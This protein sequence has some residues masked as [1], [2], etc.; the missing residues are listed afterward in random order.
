[1]RGYAGGLTR[2]RSALA[3]YGPVAGAPG[4]EAIREGLAA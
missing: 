2:A 4:I 3:L 1:V